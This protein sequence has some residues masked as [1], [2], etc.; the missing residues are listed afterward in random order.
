MK[1]PL[2]TILIILLAGLLLL[3]AFLFRAFL[4]ENFVR[5]VALVLWLLWRVLLSIDQR[6][7]WSVLIFAAL[8]FGLIRLAQSGLVEGKPAP[9]PDA[10]LTLANIEYWRTFILLTADEQAQVN[11][12]K[13]NLVEILTVMINTNQPDQ[14]HWEVIEGLKK[15]QIPLP[16][17]V[18]AFLFPP[19]PLAH[20]PSFRQAL[21]NLARLPARWAAR[22]SR[23]RPA[24]YYRSIDEVL[25]FME[26]S[27][28]I[29]HVDK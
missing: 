1:N 16:G 15:R 14:P 2:R 20:R 10:Y 21:Q 13:Q 19:R 25:T 29:P 5:P 6:V 11:I 12:L 7:V 27:L 4:L 17:D 22:R 8:I 26:S 3:L 18:H 24:E 9:V 23:R 28:E